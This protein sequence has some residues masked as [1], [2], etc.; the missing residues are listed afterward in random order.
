M[1]NNPKDG[2]ILLDVGT[3]EVEFLL[4]NLGT[5]R[6]GINVSKVCTIQVVDLSIVAP[7]PNQPA[8]IL[9]VMPFRDKTISIID[10]ALSLG[11]QGQADRSLRRLLV[12]AEFNQ[13]T[14]GFVV[15]AVDRI[16]R[17]SWGQFE[18]ITETACS[19]GQASILG[20]IRLADGLILIIDLETI[21]AGLDPTMSVEHFAPDI[22][23]ATIPRAGIKIVHCDDSFL[24]Q[25][26]VAKV[27][28][29]AG[30]DSV[31]QFSNGEEALAYLREQGESAVDIIL[32]DIEMPKM[33][34]LTFCKSLRTESRFSAVPV[35]F[36]SSLITEQMLSKCKSV[37]GNGAYSKPQIN[38]LVGEIERLVGARRSATA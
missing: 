17:F 32:S 28:S 4:I 29:E 31:L 23:V 27:L 5:Q 16:E 1:A 25:K 9:G 14:I 3:N 22:G 35:V 19:S 37:G 36:F 20:T 7:L 2:G 18:P 34:G 15:D 26:V 38:Q 21:M 24:I 11:W 33:D 13:R 30:F 6:Y 10:L 8:E 12:V